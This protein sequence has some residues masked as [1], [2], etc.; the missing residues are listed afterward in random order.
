MC[1]VRLQRRVAIQVRRCCGQAHVD[2]PLRLQPHAV[3]Q[4]RAAVA[5]AQHLPHQAQV[6]HR[7]PHQLRIPPDLLVRPQKTQ[8]QRLQVAAGQWPV[9]SLRGKGRVGDHGRASVELVEVRL[10]VGGAALHV[11]LVVH[12]VPHSVGL[13]RRKF[14]QIFGER[15]QLLV[16][17]LRG[18]EAQREAGQ[19]F[20]LHRELETELAMR[21]LGPLSLRHHRAGAADVHALGIDR[22]LWG[23]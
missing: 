15:S 7:P 17:V 8:A 16:E 6:Q 12:H 18:P 11:A 22:R 23:H 1:R 10:E 13:V 19:H 5:V 21:R 3:L 14:W 9:P 2:E 20:A 4:R